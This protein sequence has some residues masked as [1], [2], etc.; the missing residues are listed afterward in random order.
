M[1][2]FML[3]D[4][5]INGKQNKQTIKLLIIFAASVLVL[6]IIKQ[7]TMEQQWHSNNSINAVAAGIDKNI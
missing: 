6:L 5:Q 2:I 4:I 7:Q 3:V 1:L